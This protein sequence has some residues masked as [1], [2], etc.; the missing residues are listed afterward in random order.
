MSIDKANLQKSTITAEVIKDTK[1][2]TAAVLVTRREKHP[3][4]HKYIVRST[5]YLVHDPD[6]ACRVGDV[7]Q[8][9]QTRPKSKSINWKIVRILT[10]K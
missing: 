5:K 10:R 6:N 1:Q 4:Y 7:V 9:E 8:I 2:N 3:V